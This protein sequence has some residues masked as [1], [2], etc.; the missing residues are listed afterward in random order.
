MTEKYPF[1]ND[2]PGRDTLEAERLISSHQLT[3]LMVL[4]SLFFT[5]GFLLLAIGS[6]FGNPETV[7]WGYFGLFWSI[8]FFSR[9]RAET[10]DGYCRAFYRWLPHPVGARTGYEFH[11]ER[12]LQDHD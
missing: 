8:V 4:G 10:H 3:E 11:S 2:D 5:A 6:S 12:F 1:R 9:F 7:A